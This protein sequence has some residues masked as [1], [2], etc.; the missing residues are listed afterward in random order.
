MKCNLAVSGVTYRNVQ[1]GEQISKWTAGSWGEFLILHHQHYLLHRSQIWLILY[2]IIFLHPFIWTGHTDKLFDHK[3]RLLAKSHFGSLW[4]MIQPFVLRKVSRVSTNLQ[5]LLFWSQIGKDTK[6]AKE[7]H[8]LNAGIVDE[9]NRDKCVLIQI[10]QLWFSSR[11]LKAENVCL[12]SYRRTT[13]V[14]DFSTST[15]CFA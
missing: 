6:K 4:L 3:P 1:E 13:S 2:W 8:A 10:P 9:E 11:W 5:P 12:V 14:A 7:K 15:S